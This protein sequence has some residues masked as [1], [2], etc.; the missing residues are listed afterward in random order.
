MMTVKYRSRMT[1]AQ[2]VAYKFDG[3]D[4]LEMGKIYNGYNFNDIKSLFR[5]WAVYLG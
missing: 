4:G 1:A 5:K 3:K 2:L